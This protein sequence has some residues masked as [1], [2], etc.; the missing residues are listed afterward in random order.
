MSAVGALVLFSQVVIGI[1]G[2]FQDQVEQYLIFVKT[3]GNGRIQPHIYTDH[4]RREHL[5][6][7]CLCAVPLPILSGLSRAFDAVDPIS[8]ATVCP[9][10]QGSL[11]KRLWTSTFLSRFVTDRVFKAITVD[12]FRL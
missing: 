8:I 3:M 2:F 9:P 7:S 1:E 4:A 6:R 5:G 10:F 11:L 12:S